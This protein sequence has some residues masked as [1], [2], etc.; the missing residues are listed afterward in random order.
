MGVEDDD[1]VGFGDLVVAGE[2]D[3]AGFDFGEVLTAAV[4]GYV[5]GAVGGGG[6]AGGWDV[7]V[8][9]GG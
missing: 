9:G 6:L 3:E 7:N 8:A 4:E 1:V 2:G 5:E